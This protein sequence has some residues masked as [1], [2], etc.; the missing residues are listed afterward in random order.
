MQGAPFGRVGGAGDSRADDRQT[1]RPPRR[2][3]TPEVLPPTRGLQSRHQQRGSYDVIVSAL[4]RLEQAKKKTKTQT[5][6][7]RQKRN[8][9]VGE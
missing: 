7:V 3:E 2:R 4:Q 1:H 5:A 8:V 6:F 9:S